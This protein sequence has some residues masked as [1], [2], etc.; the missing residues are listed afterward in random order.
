MTKHTQGPWFLGTKHRIVTEDEKLTICEIHN[1]VDWLEMQ[2]NG[3]LIASAPEM[4]ETLIY[5]RDSLQSLGNADI[6]EREIPMIN[7][8]IAKAEGK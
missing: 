4:L 8:M 1:S 3:Y 7:A 2:P 5:L 6:N